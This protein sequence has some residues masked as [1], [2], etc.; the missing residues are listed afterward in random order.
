M[1]NSNR[2]TS[3]PVLLFA[4]IYVG[5]CGPTT[6]APKGWLPSVSDAQRESYGGWISVRYHT[7]D[8]ESEVHGELVAIHANQVL[9]L[10]S[11]ELISISHDTISRM[12]L[13]NVQL[14]RDADVDKHRQMIYPLKPLGKF[15]AY[16]RFPQGLSKTFDMQFLK[17][18][19]GNEKISIPIEALESLQKDQSAPLWDFAQQTE[20]VAA[21]KRDANTDHGTWSPT[22]DLVQRSRTSDEFSLPIGQ[23]LGK[24]PE[25]VTAYAAAYSTKV[26]SLQRRNGC[27][28]GAACCLGYVGCLFL[29]FHSMN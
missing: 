23:L 12:K 28:T 29:G 8:S 19:G 20:A 14:S 4:L 7:G 25:Y 9:I 24:S 17:P 26:K 1:K 5:G 10:T 18:K 22:R 16:A 15:R 11:Q 27:I 13:T 3:L 2:Y 21:A 6:T